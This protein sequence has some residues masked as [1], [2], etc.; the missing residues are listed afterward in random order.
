MAAKTRPVVDAATPITPTAVVVMTKMLDW[1]SGRG[2][3]RGSS[4]NKYPNN[5]RRGRSEAE[6][7]I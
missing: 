3:L 1:G 5:P 6:V 7:G 4:E 2:R